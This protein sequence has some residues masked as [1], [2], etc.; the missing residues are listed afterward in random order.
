[1]MY[2]QENQNKNDKLKDDILYGLQVGGYENYIYG[3]FSTK[4]KLMKAV[5]YL[6]LNDESEDDDYLY[7]I[8]KFKIDPLDPHFIDNMNN[9]TL[10]ISKDGIIKNIRLENDIPDNKFGFSF[11]KDGI[12][13]LYYNFWALNEE[14]AI[15]R[16]NKL[17]LILLER[18]LWSYNS[19]IREENERNIERKQLIR[20]ICDLL[21]EK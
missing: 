1:M 8:V 13:D 3:V 20:E 2:N 14:E 9:Y 7:N 12:D 17:R 16:I 6:E 10:H 19:F 18:N 11:T 4:E 21:N 5:D 15:K